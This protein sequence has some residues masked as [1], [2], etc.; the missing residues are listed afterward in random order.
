MGKTIDEMGIGLEQEAVGEFAAAAPGRHSLETGQEQEV[1]QWIQTLTG[2]RKFLAHSVTPIYSTRWYPSSLIASVL[3]LT[4]SRSI[5]KKEL[6]R[7][8]QAIGPIGGTL[9]AGA[10]RM[11][12]LIIYITDDDQG[13]FIWINHAIEVVCP[14]RTEIIGKTDLEI[15]LQPEEAQI[16]YET[17]QKVISTQKPLEYSKWFHLPNVDKPVYRRIRL[18]PIQLANGKIGVLGKNLDLTAQ[19][20]LEDSLRQLN[21]QLTTSKLDDKVAQIHLERLTS[22]SAAGVSM[23]ERM[24]GEAAD[25]ATLFKELVE[26]NREARAQLAAAREMQRS[27]LP[28][29]VNVPAIYELAASME[30]SVEVGGDYYDY[31]PLGS[32]G[33]VIAVGDAT[34]HGVK[35][36]M[37]VVA[38]RS[39]FQLMATT[40]SLSKMMAAINAGVRNMQM[41]RTYMGL[42][43]LCIRGK[44][45]SYASGG[46]PPM[47]LW[48]KATGKVETYL[49]K[50]LFL[51]TDMP[52]TYRVHEIQL[53]EGD[54]VVCMSDGFYEARDPQ[55]RMVSALT[56]MDAIAQC[57]DESP[58]AVIQSL[59]AARLRH[60]CTEQLEDDATCLALRVL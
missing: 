42:S 56:L 54:M 4:S 55:G 34:G 8:Q 36:G 44:K 53:E 18:Q 39:Y 7:T 38:V 26:Q 3:D 28:R 14:D 12:S 29:G 22:D 1:Q 32:D 25:Q 41:H 33:I 37:L 11:K 46:M 59:K 49:I 40:L 43:V 48:R 17:K 23:I 24:T 16:L 20:E 15:G 45:L 10:W 27:M 30:S 31:L 58:N 57:A 19:K 21:N 50:G 2:E 35:A 13:R 60:T 51:G 5:W 47:M 9:K 52:Q 6:G